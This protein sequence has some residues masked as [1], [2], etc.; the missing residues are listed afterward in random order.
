[1]HLS[2]TYAASSAKHGELLRDETDRFVQVSSFAV[3]DEI[4]Q[5]RFGETI[6][7]GDTAAPL[8]A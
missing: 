3:F 4:V 1:M 8:L 7:S 5:K 2:D 6:L